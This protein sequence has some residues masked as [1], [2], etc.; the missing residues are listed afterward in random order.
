M[1]ISGRNTRFMEIV[2]KEVSTATDLDKF[3]RFPYQLYKN[4]AGWIPPLMKGEYTILSRSKNP[5]FS[6]AEMVLYLA[7][8]GT[9]LVG[10]IAGI[11]NYNETAALNKN[12]ARF[13]SM[14]FVNDPQVSRAL[15]EAVEDWAGSKGMT[16][17]KGPVGF[18]N[19][20]SAGL[21]TEGFNEPGVFATTWNFEYYPAHLAALGYEKEMEWVEFEFTLPTA[22][23]DRLNQFSGLLKTR[24]GMEVY[25]FKSRTELK[26]HTAELFDLLMEAYRSLPTY[27]PMSKQQIEW[28]LNQYIG[29]LKPNYFTVVKNNNNQIIGFGI[30]LPS[31]ANAMKK[32]NGSLFPFGFYHV[33][34]ALL[35]NDTADLVLIGV[36]DEWRKKGVPA[37]I[38]HEQIKVFIQLG[39]S[40]IKVHPMLEDNIHVLSLFKDFGARL[41]RRRRCLIKN[42]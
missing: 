32:A 27:V 6:N 37:L 33:L 41:Y 28:Y 19:L 14:E 4:A 40:K 16:A 42:L 9:E 20:D 11:I 24:F 29:F 30:T 17:L 36:K 10:R 26:Q 12:I 22:V 3:I 25:Q 5:I 2:I 1:Y 15:V 7:F 21:L 18:T 23:P 35:K 39:V 13:G 31:L 34:K 8:K 38:F